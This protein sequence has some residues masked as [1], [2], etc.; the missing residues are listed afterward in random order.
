MGRLTR[1]SW[2]LIAATG[3]GCGGLS[4]PSSS[5][6]N[7]PRPLRFEPNLGQAHPAYRHLARARAMNIFIEDS[8]AVSLDL[9][10]PGHRSLAVIRVSYPGSAARPVAEE[11]KTDE[12]PMAAP[13]VNYFFSRDT[14]RWVTDVPT[15]PR[16]NYRD[17]YPGIDL[18]YY[19]GAAGL[20]H[21]FIVKPG[22]AAGQ[23]RMKFEGT[24]GITSRKPA[25][26]QSIDGQKRR[27]EGRYRSNSDG[28]VGFEV[29]AYDPVRELVINPGVISSID[30]GR[31]R[32][33]AIA[34]TATDVSGNT[35]LTGA[36][37]DAQFPISPGAAVEGTQGGSAIVT[38]LNASGTAVV[39]STYLGGMNTDSGSGIAVDAGGNVTVTGRTDSPDFPVT[40]QASRKGCFLTRLNAAGNALV[41]SAFDDCRPVA[42]DGAAA[43]SAAPP[44]VS[45]ASVTNGASYIGGALSPGEVAVLTGV[46]IGPATLLTAAL[47][48]PNTIS[49]SVGDTRIL[50]DGVPAPLIYVSAG[51]SAAVVPYG[52]ASRSNTSVVV[53]HRGVRSPAVSVSVVPLRPA[54]FTANSSGR[55]PCNIGARPAAKGS[56]VVLYGTGHG[57]TDPPGIDGRV[58][59]SA[60]IKMTLP[61]SVEI[62]GVAAK[63]EYAGAAPGVVAGVFQM[64]VQ[65]PLNVAA[66]DQTV[67]VRIG[68]IP[69]QTGVTVAV[70]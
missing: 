2:I 10:G 57:Q 13:R 40:A 8:G 36:S 51:Q 63:I 28:S 54:L 35:Y 33:D 38:K 30:L 29:G 60:R 17:I 27:V 32:Q 65:V 45:I 21:D 50:F 5:G 15:Y 46:N 70:R 62:G 64:N 25:L 37:F 56:V 31:G 18:A 22:A 34:A 47:A 19:G 69:T 4:R 43:S 49:T 41:F 42:V 58:T 7:S 66:G 16:V 12:Q 26:H 53:E 6:P 1:V 11:Q 55:G 68:G 9:R 61:V 20:E 48:D 67:L 59:R 52:V 23:I 44:P 3:V 14:A 39:W 24:I